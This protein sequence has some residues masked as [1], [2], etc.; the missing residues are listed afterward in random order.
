VTFTGSMF[1]YRLVEHVIVLAR[2]RVW[3]IVTLRC[4]YTCRRVVNVV[5]NEEDFVTLVVIMMHTY[6]QYLFMNLSVPTWYA[7]LQVGDA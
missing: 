3:G 6:T 4:L 1:C 5:M 2:T 7:G